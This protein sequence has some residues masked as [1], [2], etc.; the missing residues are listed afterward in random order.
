MPRA[1]CRWR[2]KKAV[3][4]LSFVSF[5]LVSSPFARDICTRLQPTRNNLI[6]PTREEIQINKWQNEMGNTQLI[7]CHASMRYCY[8]RKCCLFFFISVAK[9]CYINDFQLLIEHVGSWNWRTVLENSFKR[10][11]KYF[12]SKANQND[13]LQTFNVIDQFLRIAH[14]VGQ[15]KSYDRRARV[16]CIQSE[17]MVGR[18]N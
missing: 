13:D 15:R 18:L 5:A 3:Q 4:G 7:N 10:I 1:T 11:S 8:M 16:K 2:Q 12:D 6:A 17:I 14:A 9:K